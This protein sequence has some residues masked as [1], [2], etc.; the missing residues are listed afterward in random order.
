MENEYLL[1][2]KLENGKFSFYR[3]GSLSALKS[4]L[5]VTSESGTYVIVKVGEENIVETKTIP[6]PNKKCVLFC[7]YCCN[8]IDYGD[9]V[10]LNKVVDY[11]H[12]SD[13]GQMMVNDMYYCSAECRRNSLELH[14]FFDEINKNDFEYNSL[15]WCNVLATKVRSGD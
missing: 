10:F 13:D 15:D 7:D 2:K 9:T 1:Y 14:T 3:R 5:D 12:T 11:D 6:E 4:L 8:A